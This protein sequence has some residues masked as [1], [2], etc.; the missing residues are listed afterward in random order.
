MRYLGQG[1]EIAVTLPN[2]VLTEA[3]VPRIRSA[4]DTEYARLYDRPVPG[5]DVEILSYAVTV[6][7][8]P[9][10]PEELPP[11]PPGSWPRAGTSRAVRNTATGATE[12]WATF[13]RAALQPGAALSGPAIIAEA[14]TS[15]LVGPG[16]TARIDA[17]GCIDMIREQTP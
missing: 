12:E 5:S 13:E 2:G 15:T 17:T 11:E 4:Y 3:E 8:V 1:H 9:P 6:A 14:E 16:W 7:T 10:P